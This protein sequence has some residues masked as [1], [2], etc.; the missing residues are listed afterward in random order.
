MGAHPGPDRIEARRSRG[1]I[2]EC[3]LPAAANALAERAQSVDGGLAIPREA[4]AL[5]LRSGLAALAQCS[6]KVPSRCSS[7]F[8]VF[9]AAGREL[10]LVVPGA[11]A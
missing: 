10:P 9:C 6:V 8:E 4:A 11:G 1:P 3:D 7:A 2:G 5:A